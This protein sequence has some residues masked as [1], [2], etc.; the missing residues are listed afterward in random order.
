M[1]KL[2]TRTATGGMVR[3]LI[4]YPVKGC[5]GISLPQ[6]TIALAGLAHD[7]SFMVVGPGGVFRSQRRDPRLAVIRPQITSD[8]TQLTLRA[9]EAEP[10]Q[11]DVDLSL[12]RTEVILFGA[13][14]QGI[15]QGDTVA[16]WLSAVLGAP[17][18]LVRVPPEHGRVSNGAMTGTSGYADSCAVHLLSRSSLRLLNER[19]RDRGAAQVPMSRFRPNIVVDG[20]PTPHT[21]DHARRLITGSVE[22]VYAKPAIRCAVTVVDQNSGNR[23]GPEPLRTLAT[24]RRGRDGLAFGVK[25]VV[26]RPGTVSLGD[27]V[28]AERT[29]ALPVHHAAD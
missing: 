29:R 15:D 3:E 21:E 25:L 27:E 6:A 2:L 14:Y 17:S 5:G 9:P 10:V 24:Y 28:R 11:V 12:P 8:G 26:T 20:W 7:R 1:S 4:S 22:L 16:A 23:T 18:R 13:R 19:L